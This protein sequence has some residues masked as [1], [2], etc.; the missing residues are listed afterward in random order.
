[1]RKLSTRHRTRASQGAI[2]PCAGMRHVTPHAAGVD[3]GAPEMLAGVPDGDDQ[4]MIRV[5]GT[6]TVA[7]E[8]LADWCLDRGIQTVAMASTGVSWLPRFETLAARGLQGCVSSAAS[9]TRVPGHTSDGLDS[10]WLQTLHRSG[11]LSASCRPDADGVARR[12][13]LRHRAPLLPHR[14]PHVLHMPQ[15]L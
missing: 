12:T 6:A 1:M 4:P 14:A 10:Q 13:L 2:R 9:L 7:R 11:V 15:A 8:A 3:L 5:F